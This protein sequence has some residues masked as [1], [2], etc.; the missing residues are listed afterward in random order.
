MRKLFLIQILFLFT[1]PAFGQHSYSTSFPLTE[2]PISEGGKWVN[3]GSG[4]SGTPG[5]DWTNILTVSGVEA[6]GSNSGTS[7]GYDDSTAVLQGI[8]FTWAQNQ[9]ASG[10]VYLHDNVNT[11]DPEVELRLNT[12]ISA[13]SITGYMCSFSVKN[14]GSQYAGFGRWNGAYGNFT[15]LGLVTG[16]SAIVNG[17]TISC[18]RVGSTLTMFHNGNLLLTAT[19]STYLGGSPGISTNIDGNGGTGGATNIAFGISCFQASDSSGGAVTACPNSLAFGAVLSGTTS[20]SRS[21][22]V[23]NSSGGSITMSQATFSGT[24]AGDFTSTGCSGTLTNGSTCTLSVFFSP[25]GSPALN[26]TGTMQINYTGFAGSPPLVT[27]TGT[28]RNSTPPAAPTGL[29]SM[30][31]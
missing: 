30:V 11:Q 18:K 4:G 9:T 17:D 2:N 21:V 19:D 1:L 6:Y 27:L 31:N 28:S 29:V 26:E 16:F 13:H 12:T 3:G 7:P 15:S 25:T 24:N 20:A 8:G 5:I 23:T 10:V 22:I 14:D